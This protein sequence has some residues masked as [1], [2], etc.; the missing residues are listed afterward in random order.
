[1]PAQI[2]TL[3]YADLQATPVTHAFLSRGVR[4][5]VKTGE[6]VAEW[7]DTDHSG[8]SQFG[9]Y[10][11]RLYQSQ[12]KDGKLRYRA[13]IA[14]PVTATVNGALTIVDQDDV[15]VEVRYGKGVNDVRRRIAFGMARALSTNWTAGTP[16]G[17]MYDGGIITS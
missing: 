5:N 10:A 12:S 8:G 2:A 16:G 1:M 9:A 17:A 11:V 14:L 15:I 4:Q 6:L 13:H 3:S 7:T